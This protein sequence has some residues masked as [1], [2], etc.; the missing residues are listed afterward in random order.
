[1]ARGREHLVRKP[2]SFAA[3]AEDQV[4]R[5]QAVVD[6]APKEAPFGGAPLRIGLDVPKAGDSAVFP[7]GIGG[8]RRQVRGDEECRRN[9]GLTADRSK[10]DRGLYTTRDDA[11]PAV[12]LLQSE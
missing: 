11:E 9:L 8:L 3:H 12:R 6:E 5:Q 2:I 10:L 4:G 1:M 7:S